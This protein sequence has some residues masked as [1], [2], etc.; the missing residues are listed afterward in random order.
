MESEPK[1]ELLAMRT[2][3]R[4]PKPLGERMGIQSADYG[5]PVPTEILIR[6]G[7]EKIMN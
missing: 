7:W 3:G 6:A 5:Y 1:P 4:Q 2:N